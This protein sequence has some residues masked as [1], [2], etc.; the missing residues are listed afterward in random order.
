MNNIE[1]GEL[2]NKIRCKFLY[3][4]TCS[5]Y[6]KMMSAGPQSVKKR[7]KKEKRKRMGG[8]EMEE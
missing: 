4:D 5:E 2:L 1:L 7:D 6:K 3:C 8:N